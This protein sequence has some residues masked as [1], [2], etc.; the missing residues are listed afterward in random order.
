MSRIR[1]LVTAAAAAVLGAAPLAAQSTASASL[2]V[3]GKIVNP[4]SLA[5]TAP[6][7]FGAMFVGTPKAIA[8]DATGSGRFNVSGD[9]G[10]AISVTL[11]MPTSVATAGGATIP[12]SNWSYVIGS[13]SALTGTTPVSF[14]PTAGTAISASLNGTSGV[15]HV[16]FGVGA[17]A[18]P[19]STAAAGTYSAT[20]QITVAYVG[21]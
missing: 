6:L 18:S 16:Y 14:S 11:Q 1:S 15:G 8:P 5:V 4:I 10:A 7:D 21:M 9:A 13:S 19:S 2:S 17:T 12:L 3:T 20:G